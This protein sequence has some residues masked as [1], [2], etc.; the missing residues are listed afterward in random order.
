MTL[1]EDH[2]AEEV[3]YNWQFNLPSGPENL[4]TWA[5][6]TRTTLQTVSIWLKTSLTLK[7]VNVQSDLKVRSSKFAIQRVSEATDS[8]QSIAGYAN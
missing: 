4:P 5:F 8:L 6:E 2:E 1:R 7:H 3:K